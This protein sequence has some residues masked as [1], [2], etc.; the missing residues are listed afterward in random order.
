[1]QN[2]KAF[3]SCGI[4]SLNLFFSFL[5]PVFCFCNFILIT[6]VTGDWLYH[7]YLKML[8]ITIGQIIPGAAMELYLWKQRKKSIKVSEEIIEAHKHGFTRVQLKRHKKLFVSIL[9]IFVASI[10]DYFSMMGIFYQ[11]NLF[12]LTVTKVTNVFMQII[13]YQY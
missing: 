5:S 11:V 13:M 7:H 9:I 1:M 12:P 2:K 4:I 8:S 10:L 6:S 3:V